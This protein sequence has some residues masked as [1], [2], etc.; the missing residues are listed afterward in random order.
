MLKGFSLTE[1]VG[2]L[3][4]VDSRF[5]LCHCVSADL[6]MGKGIAVQFKKRFGRVGE[7]KEQ[8]KKVGEAAVLEDADHGR[9]IYY[10]ITKESYWGKPTYKT[11]GKAL[12]EMRAHMKAKGYTKL[13]MPRIGCGL[14]K[15]Q[16]KKVKEVISEVFGG[17]PVQ[18]VVYVL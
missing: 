5:C 4:T 17:T 7:L 16:W 18:V 14:D 9:A 11:L 3:F 8:G 1:V 15:L 12:V 2:D 13:A 10:L 6:A